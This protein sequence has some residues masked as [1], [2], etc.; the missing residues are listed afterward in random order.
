MK[1]LKIEDITLKQWYNIQDILTVQDEYTTYNLLD[2]LYGIDS[3]SMT[4]NEI[5]EYKNGLTFLNDF[6]NF[7]DIQLEDSYTVNGRCY[8]GFLNITNI[9]VA[10]FID[11]QNYVKEK[12]IKYEKILSVFLIPDGKEY[13]KGYSITQAQEDILEMPFIIC[14]K[15]AFFLTKQLQTFTNLF[16]YYLRVDIAKTKTKDKK[17]KKVLLDTIDK[18]N[19]LISE[20]SPMSSNTVK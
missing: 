14:Q 17:M 10:Q 11:Y 18:T 20:L 19:S 2:Y 13:N 16:L 12:P 15:V 6:D 8:R 4:I 1:T 7:K 9:T 5:S 3:M